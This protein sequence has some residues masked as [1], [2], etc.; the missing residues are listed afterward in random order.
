MKN[1]KNKFYKEKNLLLKSKILKI[2]IKI[3][4]YFNGNILIL[5]I[6]NKMGCECSHVLY[7]KISNYIINDEN[8][9]II[10]PYSSI[11]DE[12][13]YKI[14]NKYN[15]FNKININDFLFSLQKYDIKNALIKDLYENEFNIEYNYNNEFY[16][17][18]LNY[19]DFQCFLENKIINHNN[20][21][22]QCKNNEILTNIFKE[23]FLFIYK[24]LNDKLN[25]YFNNINNENNNNFIIY[26]GII[27]CIGFL[28]CK[29]SNINKINILFNLFKNKEN[30]FEFSNELKIFLLSLFLISSY[31]LLYSINKLSENYNEIKQ[32]D[33]QTMKEFVNIS[34]L[35]DN[36][37]LINISLNEIFDNNINVNKINYNNFLIKFDSNKNSL[38]WI[39]STKGIRNKLETNN[40]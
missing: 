34:E 32:I 23:N 29:S 37:N 7:N 39:L 21:Y 3:N 4:F 17:E 30:L 40:I 26:K 19:N 13:F 1:S 28:F 27:I 5:I 38:G 20:L 31:C 36:I 14:E 25:Q 11:Q 24:S 6:I 16:K 18:K 10:F 2:I 35:K 15:L 8:E 33:K 12:K 22:I 9:I